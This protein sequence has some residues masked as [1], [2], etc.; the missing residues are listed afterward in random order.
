MQAINNILS[1]IKSIL[2]K[3][4]LS[5]LG[6]PT[7]KFEF[8]NNEDLK[9]FLK[10]NK[11]NLIESYIDVDEYQDNSKALN[12]NGNYSDELGKA[13]DLYIVRDLRT[14]AK[15][16]PGETIANKNLNFV[17]IKDAKIENFNKELYENKAFFD[18]E[19]D[20]NEYK[21]VRFESKDN[22]NK[23]EFV[24]FLP[25]KRLKNQD[26]N[27]N[28]LGGSFITVWIDIDIKKAINIQINPYSNS[29]KPALQRIEADA[30]K[31]KEYNYYYLNNN[32]KDY[33]GW[34]TDNYYNQLRQNAFNKFY[35]D[36]INRDERYYTN[37]QKKLLKSFYSNPQNFDIYIVSRFDNDFS[38]IDNKTR[39]SYVGLL[40][41]SD[42]SG[43]GLDIYNCPL[44]M[45]DCKGMNPTYPKL[46]DY[47]I[48]VD[49][50]DNDS[51]LLG[52]GFEKA[53]IN[54]LRN[55]VLDNYKQVEKL[56]KVLKGDN[57]LQT[58]FNIWY[59]LHEN[60]KYGLDADGKEEIRT[61]ARCWADRFTGVDCDCLA[62]LTASLLINLGY[63]P[64]FEIVA[65]NNNPNYEH[66][67][68]VV[69]DIVIDRVLPNFNERPKNITKKLIMDIPVYQLSGLSGCRRLSGVNGVTDDIL[70]V[71]N[72]DSSVVSDNENEN[73]FS[74]V[75]I[76]LNQPAN[77][78]NL[79]A[80][81]DSETETNTSYIFSAVPEA[82]TKKT[83]T[84]KVALTF[85]AVFS[86]LSVYALLKK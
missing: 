22:S 15:K 36:Y 47:S 62:V 65:M 20:F 76:N 25:K 79:P 26:D 51:T 68:V 16:E 7:I 83:N 72:Y 4:N 85:F 13:G 12:G 82:D 24:F 59:F 54:T 9:N 81:S 74:K 10:E 40:Q 64:K 71:K 44:S 86:T 60:I 58:F 32:T 30:R 19:R 21:F 78:G 53:T 45:L 38:K 57:D 63:E 35:S 61:P 31:T 80:N 43:Y 70:S 23:I 37:Y 18:F 49:R 29:N 2:T 50:A 41:N 5:E 67:Y 33:Y 55:T 14:R 8:E 34:I 52:F 46:A 39:D 42:L 3:N 27:D 77:S 56:A 6:K 1:G 17:K 84:N 75:V 66:I 69:D 28:A 11:E 48:Y 73:D